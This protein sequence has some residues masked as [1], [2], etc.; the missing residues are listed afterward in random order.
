[1]YQYSES[2]G[3]PLHDDLYRFIIGYAIRYREL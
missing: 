1:M 2:D 3:K